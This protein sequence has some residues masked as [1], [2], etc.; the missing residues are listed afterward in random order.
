MVTPARQPVPVRNPYRTCL[1]TNYV[2]SDSSRWSRVGLIGGWRCSAIALVPIGKRRIG[3]VEDYNPA[4]ATCLDLGDAGQRPDLE[5]SGNLASRCQETPT[6]GTRGR[7]AGSGGGMRHAGAMSSLMATVS[8]PASKPAR[9]NSR[10]T[11][12]CRS[13]RRPRLEVLRGAEVEQRPSEQVGVRGGEFVDEGTGESQWAG[14]CGVRSSAGSADAV[15][16][17]A[18][19]VLGSGIV[20]IS[21][22]SV[23]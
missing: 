2:R 5:R 23:A 6:G 14:L 13:A 22:C 16:A 21:R 1:V 3:R 7:C 9:A 15:T 8:G 20:P 10:V 4:I 11:I 17:S 12:L 18:H 19:A